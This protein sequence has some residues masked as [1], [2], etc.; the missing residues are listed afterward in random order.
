MPSDLRLGALGKSTGANSD[1]TS[2]TFLSAD[3]YGSQFNN[4][5]M[6]DFTVDSVS[7]LD[8]FSGTLSAGFFKLMTVQFSNPAA[9]FSKIK[10]VTSNYNWQKTDNGF[11]YSIIN[12]AYQGYF[13]AAGDTTGGGG[14]SITAGASVTYT[15][16][17]NGIDQVLGPEY[18]TV[19]YIDGN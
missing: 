18:F 16:P 13:I 6:S 14:I 19:F 3:A 17:Y 15:D 7:G 9:H 11:F 5:R 4:L 2:E 10:T 8:V 12:G 1:T